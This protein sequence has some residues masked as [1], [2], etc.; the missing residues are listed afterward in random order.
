MKFQFPADYAVRH[1]SSLITSSVSASLLVS[2]GLR[3]DV[4]LILLFDDNVYVRF[5]PRRLR[6]IRPDEQSTYGVV[7]KAVRGALSLASSSSKEFSPGVFGGRAS[8]SYF[9]KRRGQIYYSFMRGVR[10]DSMEVDRNPTLVICYPNYRDDDLSLL[11][12]FKAKPIRISFTYN[13][14]PSLI[15]IFQNHCDRLFY[16]GGVH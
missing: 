16:R 6:Y 4:N 9:L 10:L 11:S 12:S 5:E 7:R 3:L 2:H 8:F 13:Y 15:V 1:F 14:P